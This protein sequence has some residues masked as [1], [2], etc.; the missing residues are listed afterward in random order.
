MD[1]TIRSLLELERVLA[2][3]GR[4]YF[5]FPVNWALGFQK[6]V[7]QE[8]RCMEI[9]PLSMNITS[10]PNSE[11]PLCLIQAIKH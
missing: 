11:N 3:D 10:D 4:A 9:S 2:V 7:S 8:A 6:R 5:V 1:L